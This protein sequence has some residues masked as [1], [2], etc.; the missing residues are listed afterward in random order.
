MLF[1]PTVVEEL[2]FGPRNIG[3]PEGEIPG[4]VRHATQAL[5]LLGLEEYPPLALSFGQQK[6]SPL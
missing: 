5:N 4:S 6:R 2:A 3:K 1:A